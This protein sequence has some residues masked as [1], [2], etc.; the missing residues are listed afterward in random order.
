MSESVAYY[1]TNKEAF[2]ASTIDVDMSESYALF[3][4][5]LPKRAKI[6]DAGCGSGRDSLAFKGLGY[7]VEAFDFSEEMVKATRKLAEVPVRKLSFQQMDYHDRFDGIWASASL[8][9][10]PRSEM[11]KVFSLLSEA[12]KPKG[13]LY[14]SYKYREHDFEKDGRY[15]TCYTPASF[16]QF[17]EEETAFNFLESKVSADGREGREEELW[18]TSVVNVNH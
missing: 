5:Y 15:F 2:L 12:L 9:H 8:L 18:V 10:V 13:V 7:D 17:I 1:N 6:L 3:L 4:K 16:S 11:R 14:C